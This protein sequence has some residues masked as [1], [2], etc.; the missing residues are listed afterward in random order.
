M[1]ILVHKV[2]GILVSPLA[3]IIL[4]ALWGLAANRRLIVALAL[5]GL[6]LLSIPIVSNPLFRSMEFSTQPSSEANVA[7]HGALV[8]LSGMLHYVLGPSE[9]L[10]QEWG[11]PDRFFAG[12]EIAKA[13]PTLPVILTGGLMP[14]DRQT[15]TEGEVLRDKMI[16]FGVAPDRIT[17]TGPVTNTAQEARAIA[18][19]IGREQSVVLVTSAFHMPRAISLFEAEGLKVTPW[20]VDFKVSAS[21]LTPMDFMPTANALNKSS[22][23]VR[24][25]LGRTYYWFRALL[26]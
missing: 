14:W 22:I 19:L 2:L 7:S 24:E 12:L 6:Y 3:V 23:V 4:L 25:M 26:K 10:T 18:E 15:Q 5:C 16:E 17:V 8:V 13:N 9:V 20:P 1:E 11:D 21:R